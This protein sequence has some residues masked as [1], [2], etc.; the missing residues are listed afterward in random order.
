MNCLLRQ[1]KS[2]ISFPGKTCPTFQLILPIHSK[3]SLNLRIHHGIPRG[4]TQHGCH[5]AASQEKIQSLPIPEGPMEPFQTRDGSGKTPMALAPLQHVTSLHMAVNTLFSGE[6]GGQ[7][8]VS[9]NPLLCLWKRTMMLT[10]ITWN[11]GFQLS[12][13]LNPSPGHWLLQLSLKWVPSFITLRFNWYLSAI[14]SCP[15]TL[16]V[17]K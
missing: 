10:Y 6:N 2:I 7:E 15:N 17:C 9:I 13:Y 16:N 12:A 4:S 11:P 1:H 3:F 5:V 14:F 8:A